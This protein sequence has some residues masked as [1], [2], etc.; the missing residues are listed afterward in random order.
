ML[1]AATVE[2]DASGDYERYVNP[3][4]VRLLDVLRMNVSY[5]RCLGADLETADGRRILDFN[6]GYCVHNIGHN[7]PRLVQALK[8]EL[9]R[10]GPAMLQNHVATLAGEAARRLCELAGGRLTKAFFGS[11]GSEG[12]EAAIK[13]ARAHTKRP[14]ILYANDGFHGL[15]CGALSLMSN[16]FWRQGFEPLL[17][18]TEGVA[19]GDLAALERKLATGTFAAFILEPI[20]AEAG[21]VM[22]P[23]DYLAR[24]QALCRRHRTL[25]VL[26][27][28]QT[29]LGRTGRFLAAHHYGV[30]PD[31]VV[32]AK[33]MSGGLVPSGAVLM[34]EA[35]FGSVYSSLRRALVHTSTY[36]ENGLAMRACL[37]T[38]DILEDERLAQRA[39]ASGERLRQALRQRLSD[40]EMIADIRGLGLLNA[41]EFKAPR[42]PR[43]WLAF[44]A[45]DKIHPAVFG[46]LLVMR[47]FQDHGILSQVCGNNF[48]VLKV[49]PPLG[50]E[51]G[52][53][54]RYVEAIAAVVELMHTSGTFWSEGLG[55]VRRV[56]ASI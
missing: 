35:I 38:L 18:A 36:S 46:Q 33:A 2:D 43:R 51:D 32:L 30:E 28:V 34:T 54:D 53:I 22:P 56:V 50:I 49:A 23:P 41:I 48:M 39:A 24:A 25:F 55:L 10:A 6:S 5:V 40:Y 27:E 16:P 31:M 9:D 8:D 42:S 11:S 29:G 20:Q 14:G 7:H 4:W 21:I 1:A 37:T 15:T 12:V 19:F 45:F 26:D 17:P 44:Q 47:L 3:Q 13:F 52:Q